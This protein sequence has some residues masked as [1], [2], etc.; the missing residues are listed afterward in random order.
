MIAVFAVGAAI[1]ALGTVPATAHTEASP[2]CASATVLSPRNEVRTT[3]ADP[4][5]SRAFGFAAIKIKGTTLTYAVAI[6]N[7]ARETF[8]AGH[9]HAGVAGT[10]GPVVVGLFSGM[11]SPR[12]FTQLASIQITQE[13]AD[14]ICG[15]LTGHYINYHTTQDPQGAV[16]GQ[17]S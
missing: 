8:V 7:P 17:L 15:D 1:L 13:Q 12:V 9:I 3:D 11:A 14:A 5:E 2:T 10:N 16:R 4:V 6:A